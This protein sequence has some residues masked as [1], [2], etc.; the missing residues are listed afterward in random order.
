M[1]LVTFSP[2]PAGAPR[3]GILLAD[4]RIVDVPAAL[5]SGAEFA[6]MLGII[7]AGA[8]AL[9]RLRALATAPQSTM[10]IADGVLASDSP[11]QGNVIKLT[12]ELAATA[13]S[14]RSLVEM[15]ERDPQ[16]L[17]FGKSKSEEK[18]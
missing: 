5:G 2:L 11:L 13:K 3:P 14:V 17:I 9:D 1:K 15:L 7:A 10:A 8:A 12:R 18:K 6:S 4:K 16:S